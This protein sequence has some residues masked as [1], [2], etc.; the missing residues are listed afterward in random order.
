MLISL[1]LLSSHLTGLSTVWTINN[2]GFTFTPATITI[3]LGDTVSFVIASPHAAREVSQASWDANNNTA[4]P[5][6]FETAF[7]GGIVLSANLKVG[8]HY[9]V[10]IPH[11][12]SGMKGTI[13]VQNSTGAEDRKI[14]ISN[15]SLAQ[16]YPNPF[17]PST[18]ISYDLGEQSMVTLS[19]FDIRGQEVA[20]LQ[21]GTQQ[22]GTYNVQ[23]SGI[24]G[25]GNLVSTG[26]YFCRFSTGSFSKT[27]K[28]IFLK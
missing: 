25:D 18:T 3:E 17:N 5:N 24:N 13:I 10:C 6:G 1:L 26:M 19:I 16:N 4:L 20:T 12:S 23:W 2:S 15:Y 14:L 7:G 28:M 8:T 21:K 9:Y 11:A 22:A 27:I